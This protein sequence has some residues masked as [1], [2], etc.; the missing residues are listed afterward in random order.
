MYVSIILMIMAVWLSFNRERGRVSAIFLA[1]LLFFYLLLSIAY[2]AANYFTDEGINDA[3]IFHLQYGLEGAGFKEYYGI[4]FLALFLFMVTSLLSWY[5]FKRL[6]AYKLSEVKYGKV[7]LSKIFLLS[8]FV[9]HPT[10]DALGKLYAH[11][12]TSKLSKEQLKEGLGKPFTDFYV[13][14]KVENKK[15]KPYNLVYIY[16]E[17]LEANYFDEELFPQLM[18]KL[19]ALKAKGIDFLDVEQV[20]NTGWT[21]AGMVAS[22]CA[23]PLVTPSNGNSMSGMNSFYSGATCLG[24]ILHDEGYYL[25]YMQ[26]ASLRFAGKGLFYKT[27]HFDE[28][29]GKKALIPKMKDSRYLNHWGLYDDTL[30]EFGFQRFEELASKNKP[31]A[32]VM[33]T[34]D[35]H[36]P[37]GHEAKSCE[38]LKYADGSNPMLNAVHC[39]DA[40]VAE[41]I[42]KIQNS[43][44]GEN[45]VIVLSSDHLAMKNR[46]I[47]S[48]KKKPRKNTF[49]IVMPDEK[50]LKEL[51]KIS[52]LDVAPTVLS[53]LG[54]EVPKMALGRDILKEQS[55]SNNFKQF[56]H[57]LGMWQYEISKFWN[58]QKLSTDIK[59]DA[60]AQKIAINDVNYSIPI[61]L[62]IDKE[63]RAIP[64]FDF[65]SAEKLYDHLASFDASRVFV[66][67]DDCQKISSVE[68][69]VKE[70][71][72]YC[73]AYG[74][75]GSKLEVAPIEHRGVIGLNAVK[76]MLGQKSA[77]SL[78]QQRVESLKA[79]SK[80]LEEKLY[81]KVYRKIKEQI[82][83]II[84]GHEV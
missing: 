57:L 76:E 17:S 50:G 36:H 55:L 37:K 3:V 20:K 27:H 6:M 54:V 31:F 65:D 29:L 51:Q 16:M 70:H 28:V 83:A 15:E 45:T 79:L 38:D 74:T 72:G 9:L 81:E 46:A 41:L 1:L 67:I 35:T 26:G 7:L 4:I 13:K 39:T 61:L 78:Y 30:F 14:P 52:M 21:I 48:L 5:Y 19:T 60:L 10:L 84:E 73:Y 2:L 8:A 34:V 47:E 53:S 71:K 12:P 43:S 82:E 32:L 49:F 23:L 44:Y 24:D 11:T 77:T 40:L 25:S 69:L 58:F 64:Y 62:K 66:W 59:I 18:P 68:P 63:M 33:L 75:L 80:A 56:N 42:E 22:Q